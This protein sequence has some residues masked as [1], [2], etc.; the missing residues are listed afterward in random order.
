[1]EAFEYNIEFLRKQSG[2]N[3]QKFCQVIGFN[4][5]DE[6]KRFLKQYSWLRDYN[7]DK[8]RRI[9]ILF[10]VYMSSLNGYMKFYNNNQFIDFSKMSNDEIKIFLA[11]RSTYNELHF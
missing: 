5:K 2:L 1:M 3:Y 7:D 11:V 4:S 6:Y 8:L 9:S 10:G